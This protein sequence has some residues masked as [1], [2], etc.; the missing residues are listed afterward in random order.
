MDFVFSDDM[1]DV[2]LLFSDSQT[3]VC[4]NISHNFSGDHLLLM[5]VT[6]DPQ[7]HPSLTGLS[8]Y[9][10]RAEPTT[11]TDSEN[12][13]TSECLLDSSLRALVYV[14]SSS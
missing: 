5:L 1:P 3:V 11:I 8:V 9:I 14:F 10:T 6:S 7:L 13:T 4:V 2:R 12:V